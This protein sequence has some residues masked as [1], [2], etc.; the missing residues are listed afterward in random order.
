MTGSRAE[1]GV[2]R[3]ASE[4]PGRCLGD[5]RSF[6]PPS[7]DVGSQRPRARWTGYALFLWKT[8]QE[9]HPEGALG[10][11]VDIMAKVKQSYKNVGKKEK[12]TELF[13]QLQAEIAKKRIEL[14]KGV[15]WQGEKAR[16]SADYLN[17][18]REAVQGKIGGT[19]AEQDYFFANVIAAHPLQFW[20]EGCEA[21]TVRGTVISF[22]LKPGAKPVARQPIPMSHCDELRTEYHLEEWCVQGKARKIDTSKE[23]LPEWATPVFVVDQ[24]V[25]QKSKTN[26]NVFYR[27]KRILIKSVCKIYS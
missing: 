1:T 24:D 3:R 27:I 6:A 22:R 5:G 21:P 18:M 16:R 9:Q 17:A 20:L 8:R 23:S 14:Y 19:Q 11:P 2:V 12:Q 7:S 13:P 4:V 25:W 26:W 15:T 10:D